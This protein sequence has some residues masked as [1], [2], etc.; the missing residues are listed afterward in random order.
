MLPTDP[1]IPFEIF[2]GVNEAPFLDPFVGTI[3]N[4]VQDASDPGFL[5]GDPSS[6][7]S[8]VRRVGG[9]FAQQLADGTLLYT[10]A[11]YFFEA[12]ITGL[13][14]PVGQQ[15]IGTEDVAIRVQLGATIDPA[16][17]P[18]VGM[19]LAGGLVEITAVPEPDSGMLLFSLCLSL[20]GMRRRVINAREARRDAIFA[21][22]R[23][24]PVVS[25]T[26]SIRASS[27]ESSVC[28]S[29]FVECS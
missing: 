2:G 21:C 3:S 16:T 19:A 28:E 23:Q 17:D 29:R 26:R 7:V 15:F 13:P 8:G 20:L 18:I 25:N 27:I 5:T 24:L 14:F 6:L 1:V 11:S 22:K 12:K 10:D 4:I 9:P